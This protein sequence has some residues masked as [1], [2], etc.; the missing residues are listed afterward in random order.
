MPR[1]SFVVAC[2]S[3]SLMLAPA[4]QAQPSAAM[5]VATATKKRPAPTQRR[6]TPRAA[7]PVAQQA[8]PPAADDA[9]RAAFPLVYLGTYACELGKSL[10]V[11][12]S[13]KYDAYVDVTFDKRSFVMKPVLSSTGA[14]RLED[15]RGA[16]LLVQIAAK[17]M[18]LD[19]KSGQ[20]LVDECLSEAQIKTRDLAAFAPLPGLFDQGEHAATP[21]AP[22]PAPVPAPMSAQA[23][24]PSPA[25]APVP[26]PAA[27][28]APA[29]V[30][31]PAPAPAPTPASG[32]MWGNPLPAA[33][34]TAAPASASN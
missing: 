6:A 16:G 29:S 34:P 15:Y 5:A 1:C 30:V 32:P 19:V 18:L 26:S 9:Q 24:A 33:A 25:P 7:A 11:A 27:A 3:A 4:V 22:A 20:R 17:S 31:T 14:V 23:P 8:P 12:P 21:P 2:L 28:P 13:L 10:Q